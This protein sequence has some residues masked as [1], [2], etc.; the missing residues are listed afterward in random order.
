[1][2]E[3]Q[4]A[5]SCLCGEVQYSVE[6]NFEY[7]LNCHCSKCRR[8][9]GS[10]YKSFGGIKRE[11][12]TVTQGE[13]N[14]S[15]FGEASAHHALCKTCGSILYSLVREGEYVHVT[16]GTLIDEPSLRPTAHIFVGSK[17]GWYDITD[18]LPQN[19]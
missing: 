17:A 14:L 16:Y 19:E 5:G 8:A 6:D 18:D 13:S 12:L 2:S 1:M 15:Q 10:A 11:A 4:L 9:S 7:A 3:K